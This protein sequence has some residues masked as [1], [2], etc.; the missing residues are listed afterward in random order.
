MSRPDFCTEEEISQLVHTFYAKVRRD[1]VLG[2]VF[3]SLIADWDHHLETMVDFWSS[4]LRGT[5]R[6]HGM[7]MPKHVTLPHLD[8]DLFHRW[9]ALFDETTREIGNPELAAQAIGA[10]QRIAQN[11][12][13]GYQVCRHP[14]QA[15]SRLSIAS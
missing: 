3:D 15:V 11:F 6:Y 2:P 5:G 8:E 13:Y 4:V 7:P 12:W 1:T 14:D 10:A 9:L